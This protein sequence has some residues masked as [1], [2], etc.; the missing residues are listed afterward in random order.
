[1]GNQPQYEVI[2]REDIMAAI[3]D[4]ITAALAG[5]LA[6]I[7]ALVDIYSSTAPVSLWTWGYTSRWDYDTWW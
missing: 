1:M 4:G 6:Q 7:Q 5:I 2:K 3:R